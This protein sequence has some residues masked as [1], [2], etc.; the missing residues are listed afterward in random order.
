M[1]WIK[2]FHE[3]MTCTHERVRCVHGDEI[4]QRMT[5]NGVVYR[6]ACVDCGRSLKGGLPKKCSYT[7]GLHTT[8]TQ[9]FGDP[10]K[11]TVQENTSLRSLDAMIERLQ[12][13]ARAGDPYYI[14]AVEHLQQ[15]RMELI[16]R[17]LDV[18]NDTK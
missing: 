18:A 6:R 8:S 12:P 2:R 15:R 16:R 9:D 17:A 14:E 4:W 10:P 13:G 3:W 7:D 1:G 11:F 5:A